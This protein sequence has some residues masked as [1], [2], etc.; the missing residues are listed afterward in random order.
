MAEVLTEE[1]FQSIQ[2]AL[3]ALTAQDENLE[4]AKQAGIDIGEMEGQI[5]EQRDKLLKIKRSFF[6]GR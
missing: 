2:V 5:K 3:E 6:P 4:R 1:D